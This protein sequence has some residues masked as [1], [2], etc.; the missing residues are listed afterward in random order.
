MSIYIYINL[1]HI[2]ILIT[3][4]KTNMEPENDGFQKGFSFCRGPF[5][6]SMLV[7]GGVSSYCTCR[8]QFSCSMPQEDLPGHYL[9]VHNSAAIREGL[10]G[11]L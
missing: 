5:P 2:S 8:L 10:P 1:C 9:I 7:F 6:A 11:A 3:P 4:P